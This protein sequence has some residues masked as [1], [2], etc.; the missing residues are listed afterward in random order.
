LQPDVACN[1]REG[2]QTHKILIKGINE[3]YLSVHRYNV[4]AY[5]N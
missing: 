4:T 5:G 2:V 1:Y 3:A